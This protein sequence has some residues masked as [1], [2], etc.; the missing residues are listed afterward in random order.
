MTKPEQRQQAQLAFVKSGRELEA[1]NISNL[2]LPL[3]S[4]LEPEKL[5]PVAL[6]EGLTGRIYCIQS[7][8]GPLNI[9]LKKAETL[10]N[11]VD[12]QTAFL[13]EIQR[14]SE[15]EAMRAAGESMPGLVETVYA[16]YK[17]G[18]IISR[19]ISGNIIQEFTLPLIE[20]L[21]RTLF[22]LDQTGIMEYDLCRGNILVNDEG[23]PILFDFGYAYRFEPA[24]DLNPDGLNLPQFHPVERL[25]S[26]SL[27]QF[28][29]DMEHING[30]KQALDFFRGVKELASAYYEKRLAWLESLPADPVVL[31]WQK[32]FLTF[33][34]KGMTSDQTLEDLYMLETFRSYKMDLE[35]DLH[36]QTCTKDTLKKAERI[37]EYLKNH[38]TFLK[39]NNAF[40]WGDEKLDASEL[41]NLYMEKRKKAEQWQI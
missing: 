18:I 37:L 11:N 7:E 14:R 32:G 5:S 16:S 12:G 30:R 1:G 19:W 26:R 8:T 29:M 31:T 36:G 27:M 41:L 40:F 23:C 24:H 39:E 28:L 3:A 38:F 22:A 35:D 20:Q 13:N 33:W 15:I 25:E 2:P 9:K 10:V 34:E 17:K 4:F 6:H 21:Y